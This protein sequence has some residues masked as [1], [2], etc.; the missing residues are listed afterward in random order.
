MLTKPLPTLGL[1]LGVRN[2]ALNQQSLSL[3]LVAL[4]FQ[5]DFLLGCNTGRD[6]WGVESQ[7]EEK[8]L[9]MEIVHLFCYLIMKSTPN[10]TITA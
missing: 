3:S 8:F 7:E 9:T 4:A 10:Q 6:G 1:V 5:D 2:T